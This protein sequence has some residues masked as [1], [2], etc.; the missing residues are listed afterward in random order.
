MLLTE[1]FDQLTYGELCGLK[2]GGKLGGSIQAEDYPA[3]VT[4][5]NLALTALYKAFPLRTKS[6]N[7]QMNEADDVYY[8]RKQFAVNGGS[9]EANKYII[10]TVSDPFENLVLQIQKVVD[11]EGCALALNDLNDADSLIT[12]AF[13]AL[14]IP[15]PTDSIIE[16]TYRVNHDRIIAKNLTPGTTEVYMPDTLMEP[17]LFYIASR[18][19]ASTPTLESGVNRSAEFM[20]KYNRSIA[21]IKTEGVISFNETINNK[22]DQNGWV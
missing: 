6:V 12:P 2:L 15:N 7:I 5:I 3:I 10:D 21:L 18:A 8:L 16:V 20:A 14:R 17:F 4:H 19:F 9:D 13:D 22:L 11:E 1:L